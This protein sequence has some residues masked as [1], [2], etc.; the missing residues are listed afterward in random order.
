MTC[1]YFD[2]RAEPLTNMH[3]V[4]IGNKVLCLAC[5]VLRDIGIGPNRPE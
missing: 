4:G 5:C 3:T 2:N 1:S